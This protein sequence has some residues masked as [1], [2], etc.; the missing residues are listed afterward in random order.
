MYLSNNI[1]CKFARKTTYKSA[2]L[3]A[4]YKAHL[5][6]IRTCNHYDRFAVVVLR[7][8]S[9]VGHIPRESSRVAWYFLRHG[10]EI[11]CEITGR[12]R[13]GIDGKAPCVTLSWESLN[14]QETSYAATCEGDY[15]QLGAAVYHSTAFLQ[16]HNSHIKCRMTVNVH[17]QNSIELAVFKAT[18]VTKEFSKCHL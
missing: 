6:R 9:A 5:V 18:I 8:D 4:I 7:G 2:S 13:S 1:T 17:F 12:R 16:S 15:K 11:T 3:L 14:D 10:G